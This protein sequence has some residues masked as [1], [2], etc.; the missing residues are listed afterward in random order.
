M[1]AEKMTAM[2]VN[3]FKDTFIG[4]FSYL[5]DHTPLIHNY[6]FQQT[7]WGVATAFVIFLTI[8]IWAKFIR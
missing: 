6:Y 4:A 8:F 3:S 1:V 5:I 2:M 7:M